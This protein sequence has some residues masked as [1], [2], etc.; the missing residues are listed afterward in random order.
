MIPAI[1]TDEERS[2]QD[3]SNEKILELG[4]YIEDVKLMLKT[5]EILSDP[6]IPST[7]KAVFKPI[8]TLNLQEFYNIVIINGV[9]KFNVKCGIGYA[10]IV[11]SEECPCGATTTDPQLI[12][13]G[14]E[15][16]TGKYLKNSF[17][18]KSASLI[19]SRYDRI[20]QNYYEIHTEEFFL[21]KSSA[22]AMDILHSIEIPE[23]VKS[24]EVGSDLEYS[25]FS[26]SY[27][28]RVFGNKLNV[29]LNPDF[30][31]RLHKLTQYFVECDYSYVYLEEKKQLL[32]N[33][34]PPATSDDYDALINEV[35]LRKV[36]LIIRKVTLNVKE[37]NHEKLH[38]SLRKLV[39]HSN[40]AE[41]KDTK[42]ITILI[43]IESVLTEYITALYP[44]RL[45]YTTCQLPNS[46]SNELFEKCFSTVNSILKNIRVRTY[47]I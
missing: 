5:Q 3:E 41:S 42:P 7:K 38:K 33:Q 40:I 27:V 9:R 22:F 31:H 14:E 11:A 8:L 12:T 34:L 24:S 1:L 26:E 28:I 19:S 18:D 25:N 4:L 46:T 44:S 10:E 36:N 39:K 32:K 23:D 13:I 21:T 29:Y 30:V 37:W 35:P 20:W 6:I 45:L 47:N 15:G 17:M 43:R 2:E 16:K